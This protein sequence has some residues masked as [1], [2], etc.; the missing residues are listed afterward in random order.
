[1]L[2][3]A[4]TQRMLYKLKRLLKTYAPYLFEP[5]SSLDFQLFETSEE[6]FGVP[7]QADWRPI[8]KGEDWGAPRSYGWFRAQFQPGKKLVGKALYLYPHFGGAEGMLYVNGEPWGIFTLQN[9][10]HACSCV[11]VSCDGSP[12]ELAVEMYT[13]HYVPGTSPLSNDP[14]PPPRYTYEGGEIC[15]KNQLVSDFIF[16][17]QA[18]L[19][20]AEQ[21]DKTSFRQAQVVSCL[22]GVFQQAVQSPEDCA[23]EAWEASLR[24]A[25][26]IM[27]PCLAVKNGPSAPE[28]GI[29][30][31]SHM[32][33]A[34][35]WPTKVTLKKC[36]RTYSNQLNLMEQYPEHSFFQSS[37]FH[38][39]WMRRHYPTLFQRISDK[40]AEGR[41]EPGGGVWVE[42][43]CNIPSGESMIRQFLW[44][45][46][47]TQKHFNYRSNCFWLPDTFG[48]S[49]AIPQIMKGC[50]VD[51]FV[52][53]KMSWNDTTRFPWETFYWEGIDGTRV[54][55]HLTVIQNWPS[56]ADLIPHL[57]GTEG[58]LAMPEKRVVSKRLLPYG[59]GDGGGGP[60]FEMLELARRCA[61]LEGCPK[62]RHVNA[63]DYLREL[64]R[65]ACDPPTH[66]GE[67]YLE[68]H[69]GT[70]TNLHQIKRNNR[71]AEI[72]LHDLELAE[73]LAAVHDGR[74][75]S[76]EEIAPLLEVLLVN[77]F[78]DILPGTCLQEVHELAERQVAE[79]VQKAEAQTDALLSSE[80]KDSVTLLNPLG[81]DRKDTVYLR[82]EKAPSAPGLTL[83]RTTDLD[84][85]PLWAIDG[86]EL[87]SLGGVSLGLTDAAAPAPG[88]A[89]RWDGK[90]LETPFARISFDENGFLESFFDLRLQRELRDMGRYPLNTFLLGEDLPADWDNWDVDADLEL[91]L[92]PAGELLS[93]SV[94][95]D[96]QV[97]FRLRSEYRLTEKTALR[98]DMVF[99]ASSPRIDFET[100]IDWHDRHR[101]LKAAFD[102][103]LRTDYA[104]NEIQFGCCLR[105]TTRNTEREQAMFEV[106]NH[107]YTDLSEID[108]GA[109]VL[110]DCKYGVSVKEGSIRLS[111]H[112]GGCR[113][114]NRGDAGTHRFTYSFYPHDCGFS[115]DVVREGYL[116]NFPPVRAAGNSAFDSLASVDRKNVIIDTVKPCEDSQNAFI[117]RLY[118]AT[119]AHT[120]ARLTCPKGTGFQLCNMLEEPLGEV[121]SG[122]E[123][124]LSFK[125]F[126]IITVKV[127]YKK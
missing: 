85:K 65:E 87:P 36:A 16:D 92:A 51:Y 31:H 58:G 26:E 114:D 126:E 97:E 123:L 109:A 38:L 89:F 115:G 122:T 117:L 35:L 10:N 20:L 100:V 29:V 47:Y 90:T 54:F 73:V 108:Q 127:F 25:R 62:V 21:L 81:F 120:G 7:G 4:Q 8:A 48:Y 40:I 60:M 113:P 41:Y 24:R 104:R 112:K 45:Q 49:A 28:A 125:P 111:L 106:C 59:Y 71:K 83:Q 22:T 121:Q 86:L 102:L 53:T 6:L 74:A 15:L 17:L 103:D 72:A 37:A 67:L 14:P 9:G 5:V 98:Q 39:E 78:H 2:N 124:K 80:G 3:A 84:G 79:V 55:T 34:W 46:R 107:K 118:E 19:E 68:L 44:G 99:H 56:P 91:K 33:T 11:T 57:N 23:R 64:E 1:M 69:R 82:S 52:T 61:D 50:G 101:F 93:R 110:N 76:E 18:L 42:C 96:G 12:M 13:G 70:L 32:D 66:R 119:G 27:A 75:A 77:Q 43:D 116:L 95:S 94:I 30:G 105:P 88:S 63:G